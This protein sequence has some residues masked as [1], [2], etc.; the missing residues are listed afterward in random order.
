MNKNVP[1][2]LTLLAIVIASC[3]SCSQERAYS[4]ELVMA[5]SA[6][7]LWDISSF[8]DDC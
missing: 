2:F 5:D 1:L 3:Y 8:M 6:Y 4:Q 7:I